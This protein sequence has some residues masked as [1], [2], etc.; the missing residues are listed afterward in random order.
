MIDNPWTRVN[1]KKGEVLP[2]EITAITPGKGVTVL[3]SGV[4]GFISI[5]DLSMDKISIIED[6]FAVGDKFDAMVT[7]VNKN[8]WIL[9][10]SVKELKEKENREQF[11]KYMNEQTEDAAPI[12]VGDIFGDAVKK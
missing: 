3:A 12:T 1:A 8:L 6:L 10:L 9:K 7:D 5:N 4:D 2:V 11:E